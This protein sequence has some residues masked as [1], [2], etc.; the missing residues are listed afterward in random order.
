MTKF[1]SYMGDLRRITWINF[2][3]TFTAANIIGIFAMSALSLLGILF[4]DK[5]ANMHKSQKLITMVLTQAITYSLLLRTIFVFKD[6]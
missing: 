6:K 4:V 1:K 3:S 2:K 5:G